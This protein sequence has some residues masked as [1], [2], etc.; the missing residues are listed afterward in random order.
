MT[1]TQLNYIVALAEE[2]HFGRAAMRCGV[3]QSGLSMALQAL[4]TEL[5]IGLFERDRQ[6]VRLTL[7]GQKVVDRARRAVLHSDDI[8][9]LAAGA[10][11]LRS[12][13]LSV[14][15]CEFFAPYYLPRLAIPL[16]VDGSLASLT[17][18]EGQSPQLIEQ[19]LA[20]QLDAVIA[21]HQTVTGGVT[22]LVAEEPLVAVLRQHDPLAQTVHLPLAALAEERLC[23]PSGS[24]AHDV[25]TGCPSLITAVKEVIVLPVG[26]ATLLQYVSLEGG[27][28]VMPLSLVSAARLAADGLVTRGLDAEFTRKNSLIWRASFPRPQDIEV[29]AAEVNTLCARACWPEAQK[30]TQALFVDNNCW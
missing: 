13:P 26:L 9:R 19:L 22:R 6:S 18:S 15:L 12:Q 10:Q 8:G 14:G 16:Q 3:S 7:L 2:R 11:G 24:L 20:G 23:L 5:G 4:E 1:L 28:S 17:L 30:S 25:T 29:L 21:S 27:L